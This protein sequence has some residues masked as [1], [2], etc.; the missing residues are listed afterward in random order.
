MSSPQ[1]VP[2]GGAPP[3]PPER[4]S[5]DAEGPGLAEASRLYAELTLLRLRRGKLLWVCVALCLLPVAA[6]A[7][8][9]VLGHFG[10]PLFDEL[11]QLYFRFLVPFVP[12]LLASPLVGEELEQRTLTFLFARPA[13]K[14]ALL[15]G[16]CWAVAGPFAALLGLSLLGVWLLSGL[17]APGD[18]PSLFPLF[19]RAEL[20]LAAGV[21]TYTALSALLGTWF[22]RHP[23]VVVL[24]YLLVVEAGLGSAPIPLHLLTVGWHLRNL[25]G[26][27]LP[28]GLWSEGLPAWI[29]LASV[30][31]LSG[32]A[33]VV[34]ALSLS[35][36]EVPAAD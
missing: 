31:V 10:R 21:L 1:R 18:L 33:L 30:A 23:F 9:A 8:L 12:A 17:R 4:S 15:V 5:S 29:S 36:A 13:P 14:G 25:A 20:A 22:P 16:K 27:E 26:L 7:V 11:S 34:G 35:D 3:R 32:G 28:A 19:A 2:V 24:G 6:A